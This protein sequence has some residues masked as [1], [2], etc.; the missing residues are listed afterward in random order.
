MIDFSTNL[1][2]TRCSEQVNRVTLEKNL[3]V[4]STPA[5][6]ADNVLMQIVPVKVEHL[7]FKLN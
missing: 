2:S 1:S 7:I 4:T 6:I 3:F 5:D